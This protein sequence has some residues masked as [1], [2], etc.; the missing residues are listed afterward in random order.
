M[1]E[2][3]IVGSG[4]ARGYPYPVCKKKR[5]LKEYGSK[6]L[7]IIIDTKVTICQKKGNGQA[8]CSVPNQ[9]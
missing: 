8:S 9:R 1:G 2:I 5:M 7:Q 4:E 3:R 6:D